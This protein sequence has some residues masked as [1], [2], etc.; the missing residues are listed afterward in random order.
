MSEVTEAE[1][2]SSNEHLVP[3]LA[4]GISLCGEYEGG[5]YSEPR[6][7]IARE[8]GQMVLVSQVLYAV[9]EAV[10]GERDVGQ[11][12]VVASER[13]GKQISPAG[14]VYLVDEKLQ[15]LGIA[16]TA[17]TVDKAPKSDPLLA[18]VM[19]G[20]LAPARYVQPV[21]RFLSPLFHP[22]VIAVVLCTL[23][24]VDTWLVSSGALDAAIHQSVGSPAHVLTVMGLLVVSTLFHETGHAAGCHYGGG[25]PGAIGVGILLIYPCFYTN[26]TDAYRLDRRGRLRTDLGGIYFNAIF[27]LAFSALY[28]WTGNPSLLVFLALSHLNMLQQMLPLIRLDGYYIL[29][30]LVGVPNL[31]AHVAPLLR[32]LTGRHKLSSS[33]TAALRPRVRIIVTAWVMIVVPVLLLVVTNLLM[34]LPRYLGTAIERW[35]QYWAAGVAGFDQGHTGAAALAIVALFVLLIPWAGGVVFVGRT[36]KKITLA[37]RSRR[38]RNRPSPPRHRQAVGRWSP[39]PPGNRTQP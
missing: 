18:L 13:L 32:R 16:S 30:D 33:V 29:G 3:R 15:G 39:R 22:I 24:A 34:R 28:A 12:A 2:D 19:R 8:D 35:Q 1:V 26:V 14:V 23:V 36:V 27:I 37:V 25:R 31:F 38:R 6:Y 21:A 5:G 9:A 7:V 17:E 4:D 20:V 11:V 10:D